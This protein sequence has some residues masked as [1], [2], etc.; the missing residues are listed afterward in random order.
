MK[1]VISISLAIGLLF[2]FSCSH[3]IDPQGSA[4]VEALPNGYIPS[5]NELEKLH[6]LT[7][8]ADGILSNASKRSIDDSQPI[9]DDAI[10]E[11]LKL[12]LI[13]QFGAD[14]PLYY[15]EVDEGTPS[16]ESS[17]STRTI[18]A[19]IGTNGLTVWHNCQVKKSWDPWWVKYTL[20]DRMT[21]RDTL[22]SKDSMLYC[23]K[24]AYVYKDPVTSKSNTTELPTMPPNNDDIKALIRYDVALAS[25]G[26]IEVNG[27]TKYGFFPKLSGGSAITEFWSP[28]L[29]NGYS[30]VSWSW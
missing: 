9:D 5:T 19:S 30:R 29:A 24:K 8:L 23:T 26:I 15:G 2:C 4:T 28:H 22:V 14:A 16:D 27:D 25:S 21:Y 12:L 3:T 17:I 6:L 7:P 13:G 18:V 1:K 20:T 10:I 11:S